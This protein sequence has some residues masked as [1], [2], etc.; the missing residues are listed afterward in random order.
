MLIEVSIQLE[1]FIFKLI[2]N[3]FHLHYVQKCS[4]YLTVNIVF[5][6]QCLSCKRKNVSLGE[7]S[8]LGLVLNK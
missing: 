6:V 2:K 3:P 1:D 8:S 4:L 7:S 5:E